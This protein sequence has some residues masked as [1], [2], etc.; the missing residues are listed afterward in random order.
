MVEC[1]GTQGGKRGR[2]TT[3]SGQHAVSAECGALVVDN[4]R[5]LSEGLVH[6]ISKQLR[7]MGRLRQ[8]HAR[9][10]CML[11][12]AIALQ[13]HKTLQ[14]VKGGCY[15]YGLLDVFALVL[16]GLNLQG[17]SASIGG[18]YVPGHIGGL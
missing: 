15:F 4:P 3:P 5:L 2:R 12:T 1:R 18:E 10:R 6:S 17:V 11:M 8:E 9:V 14:I 13:V 16:A 7:M